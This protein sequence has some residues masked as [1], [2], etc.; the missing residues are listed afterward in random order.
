MSQIPERRKPFVLS[1]PFLREEVRYWF[2]KK[3]EAAAKI[4][5]PG[6]NSEKS[7]EPEMNYRLVGRGT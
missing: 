5:E 3:E 4:G 1:I 6:K 2:E 7:G